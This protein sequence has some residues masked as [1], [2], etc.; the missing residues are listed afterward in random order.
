MKKELSLR[1]NQPND[2]CNDDVLLVKINGDLIEKILKVYNEIIFNNRLFVDDPT[3]NISFNIDKD[4]KIGCLIDESKYEIFDI[5]DSLMSV[6]EI[7]NETDFNIKLNDKYLMNIE[8]Y[9]NM[10]FIT[11]FLYNDSCAT[12]EA[13]FT[14]DI[15][16]DEFYN[17][18]K[19]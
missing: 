5:Y 19:E 17:E 2:C 4:C 3:A 13:F 1:V 18:I 12:Q 14:D 16:Y 10:F 6:K 11:A 7:E 15:S 8:I 9:K